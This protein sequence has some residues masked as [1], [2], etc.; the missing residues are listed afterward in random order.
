MSS[1]LDQLPDTIITSIL[2]FLPSKQLVRVSLTCRRLHQLSWQPC[3]WISIHLS[4]D[5]PSPDKAVRCILTRLVLAHNQQ[6]LNVLQITAVRLSGAVSVT[7]RSLALL[8]RNVPLLEEL[9]LQKCVHVT[10]GGLL[11]LVTRCSRLN[12]LDVT[13]CPMISSINLGNS[14]RL[15][16][17]SHLDLSECSSLDDTGL[18]MTVTN[19]PRITHLY[20][21]KCVQI[22]DT[23]VRSIASYCPQL[24]ELSL[25]DC[26]LL[27]DSGLI[28]LASIGP[29]LRY[30]S[31]AKCPSITSSGVH[32]VTSHC[33]KLRYINVR[34]CEDV[35]D[36]TLDSLS[37]SCSRLRSLDL[38]K[39]GIT[40]K[41]LQRLSKQLPRLRKL[42]VRECPGVGDKGVAA[43]AKGC[44]GLL[45]LNVQGCQVSLEICALVAKYATSCYI[46]HSALAN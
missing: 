22:S 20:L 7:D 25:S 34:G 16:S 27:T 39:C 21:R 46:E 12:H 5:C 15:I 41:G 2:S 17:L 19:C 23:G 13:G 37:R 40:D 38:G 8:S 28:S 36:S 18:A 30:L 6:G 29:S 11:D 1:L 45:H 31:I 42:S 4:S 44:P 33:Y 3:L 24:R 10:N 43:L 9:E 35:T 14:K 26:P 32:H